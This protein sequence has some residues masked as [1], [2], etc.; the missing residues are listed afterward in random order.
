MQE[1]EQEWRCFWGRETTA[2]TRASLTDLCGEAATGQTQCAFSSTAGLHLANRFLHSPHQLGFTS[3]LCNPLTHTG[4]PV[5]HCRS[6][7]Q[8]EKARHWDSKCHRKGN[9]QTMY[10]D[11][12]PGRYQSL[13]KK[14]WSCCISVVTENATCDNSRG[15]GHLRLNLR[16][17]TAVW[18]S[19]C[20]QDA[21]H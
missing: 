18:V 14:S 3:L 16:R 19:W 13:S 5:R 15:Q 1:W 2:W 10:R 17:Q 20:E 7:M 12:N 6:S 4:K 8:R 21:Q 9:I 11:P